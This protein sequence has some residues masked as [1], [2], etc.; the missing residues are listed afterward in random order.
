LGCES[1]RPFSAARALIAI[2]GQ[3]PPP[4]RFVAGADA[5][6][7]VEQKIADLQGQIDTNRDLAISLAFD[8]K[9]ATTAR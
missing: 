1:G 6:A 2:A 4:R 8:A 3:Q 5:I 7:A 9:A